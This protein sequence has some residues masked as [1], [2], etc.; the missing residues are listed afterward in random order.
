MKTPTPHNGPSC[1]ERLSARASLLN[2]RRFSSVGCATTLAFTGVLSFATGVA[3]L[4]PA[5]ALTFVLT[6][7]RMFALFSVSHCLKGDACMAGGARGV[8]AHGEGSG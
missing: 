1:F 3:G 7:A 5:L 8:G 6:F 4:A 2:L